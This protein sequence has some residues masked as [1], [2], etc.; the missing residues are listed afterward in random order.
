MKMGQYARGLASLTEYA[1]YRASFLESIIRFGSNV[2]MRDIWGSG[3]GI[4]AQQSVVATAQLLNE[5][6][7]EV[8][9]K[10]AV[11]GIRNQATQLLRAGLVEGE[12]LITIDLSVGYTR[13][14]G[15]PHHAEIKLLQ[16]AQTNGYRILSIAAGRN[17]CGGCTRVLNEASIDQL[18]QV[19]Y[20]IFFY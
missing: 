11:S 8:V 12:E 4:R 13:A 1:K 19:G 3:A 9:T 14:S 2:R 20:P 7:G 18:N 15:V 17:I 5:E 16:W 6:T 10:V